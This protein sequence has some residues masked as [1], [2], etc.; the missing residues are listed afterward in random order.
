MCRALSWLCLLCV[1]PTGCRT[2]ATSAA[3]EVPSSKPAAQAPVAPEPSPSPSLTPS[4]EWVCLSRDMPSSWG[5]LAWDPLARQ[6]WLFEPPD[7]SADCQLWR[8]EADDAAWVKERAV[9]CDATYD[10]ALAWFDS[11]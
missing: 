3:S 1:L 10:G 7:A 6:A 4:G 11:E 8:W 2:P 9:P 5:E